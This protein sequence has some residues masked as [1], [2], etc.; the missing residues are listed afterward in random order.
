M[1]RIL[2]NNRG[3]SLIELVVTAVILGILASLI[4]PSARMTTT[5]VKEIELK[6]DLREIRTAIDEYKKNYDK[7]IDAKT[8]QPVLGKNGYPETLKVL[9]E[10][11][12]FGGLVKYKQKFL[13][14]VPVDPF[15]P[16]PDGDKA[17]GMRSSVDD[18]DSHSWGGEDVY[19]VYSQSEGT[20]IDG[21]KYK[22]W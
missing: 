4:L 14:R 11:Y 8:L 5:R 9:V 22:D 15:H 20:A 2:H 18:S 19:D 10:G 6:R 1:R 21:T 7:A 16:E 17:W 13:R 12:D 3:L